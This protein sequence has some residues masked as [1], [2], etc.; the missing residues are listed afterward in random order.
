[1]ANAIKRIAFI[2]CLAAIGIALSSCGLVDILSQGPTPTPAPI[3]S[4]TPGASASPGTSTSP[5]PSIEPTLSP[6]EP[7]TPS[8]QPAPFISPPP[9]VEGDVIADHD[10]A[11]ES[12]LRGIPVQYVNAARNDLHIAYQHT[13]HGYH[14]SKGMYGLQAYKTG[15]ETLFGIT[16]NSANPVL[17]KLDFHDTAIGNPVDLS[18]GVDSLD[19]EGQPAIVAGTRAYLDD[20]A[21]ADINVVMWSWCDISGHN[22]QNYLNGMATL[23]SEYGPGGSRIG[24]G[25]PHPV[26]VTFIF[27]TGH[28]Y[29]NN[30]GTKR[31]KNQA[32]LILDF[33]AANGYFCLDYY[34]IDSHGMDGAY[35]EAASDD[36]VDTAT[37]EA[38]YADWQ[39]T[40]TESLDWFYNENQPG[41]TGHGLPDHNSQHITANRKA[42][43]M[44]WILARI[45]GWNGSDTQ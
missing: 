28:A 2:F 40:H 21:N 39:G 12:V 26:S 8:E 43:A 4:A 37:G 27:M 9:G 3:A 36:G 44:W 18:N 42:Y 20:P 34:G 31:P 17:N 24:I 45:A 29:S 35:H 11:F 23:I 15:D 41:E 16:N 14:V 10:I 7:P 38:F 6:S 25:K 30:V 33:C 32:D 13:S 22:V 5:L 1:M 19:G